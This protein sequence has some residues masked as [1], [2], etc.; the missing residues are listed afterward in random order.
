MT[1]DEQ[2]SAGVRE[3]A[4]EI[5]ADYMDGPD[6]VAL[7]GADLVISALTAAGYSIVPTSAGA[8]TVTI[9]RKELDEAVH[10]Y[11]PSASQANAIVADIITRATRGGTQ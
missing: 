6:E 7:R 1:T 9:S 4:R 8:D 2:P 10:W 3:R 5:I 11:L